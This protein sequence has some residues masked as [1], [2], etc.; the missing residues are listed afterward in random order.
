MLMKGDV[1]LATFILAALLVASIV[2]FA[3]QGAATDEEAGFVQ[4]PKVQ[5][6]LAAYN[7]WQAEYERQGGARNLILP[8]G[9]SK[10]LSCEFTTARGRASFDL[11]DGSLA[12]E[13]RGLPDEHTWEVWLVDNGVGPRNSIAPESGDAMVGIGRLEHAAGLARLQAQLKPG[14]F[15]NFDV[16]LVVVARDGEAPGKGGILFGAPSLFQRFYHSAQGQLPG[17]PSQRDHSSKTAPMTA[18]LAANFFA[19]ALATATTSTAALPATLA[20]LVEDGEVIFFSEKFNGNGRTCGT[21]HRPENNMTID[22][23]F[24]ATLP[25]ED[26]LFVAEFNPA[27]QQ[28]FE[29]PELMRRFGLILENLDGFDDLENKFVMRGVPHVL[30]LQTSVNSSQGP[31]AGWSGDGSANGSL[32]LFA[33]SAVTQH[34]TQT[35]N[36]APGV[37]FR[38]PTEAEMDALEAFLLSLG[39]Q[40]DLTLPLP[41][42]G[43]IPARGQEIFN[44]PDSGKC[45]ACHLNAGANVDPEIFPPDSGNLN[46]DSGVEDFF[47]IRDIFSGESIPPD[48]GSGTPGNGEF[49]TPPLVEAADTGPFFH[50]N[51]ID[52]LEGAVAFYNT[53]AFNDSPAGQ[54]LIEATGSG[55]NLNAIEIV[56][57]G[58]FLRVLNALENI[59]T[60]T[61][62][63]ERATQ[64]D[65]GTSGKFLALGIADIK[66]GSGVLGILHLDAQ[67]RMLIARIYSD[68]AASNLDEQ[69]RNQLINVAIL[70][71]Q[72][73]REQMI[74]GQPASI[75][76]AENDAVKEVLEDAN[77]IS[78]VVAGLLNEVGV[79]FSHADIRDVL[80]VLALEKLMAG[81]DQ[82]VGVKDSSPGSLPEN[83]ALEQNYP[84]PFNP[85]TEIRYQ[86]PVSEHVVIKVFNALGQEILTLV[87]GQYEAGQ[88][89]VRWDGRDKKGV[90]V[91]SGVYIYQIQAGTFSQAKQMSLL[92]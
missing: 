60:A 33:A 75:P 38:L 64:L 58:G 83:Y 36:R 34:F 28:N 49:N 69:Q 87:D 19:A 20:G 65:L 51:L 17:V 1:K 56:Y 50:N 32:R 48:D 46:F 18:G 66:D 15:T 31:H 40:E 29:N 61:A 74:D 55:I 21:C 10:G 42:K 80:T 91:S 16:D 67:I 8:L 81:F 44:D 90:P 9:W 88:H 24:I 70:L 79:T 57:V 53:G 85:E 52:I 2:K 59:R 62:N 39:R 35:L 71:L 86:L 78:Q 73:A 45:F 3:W 25:N 72:G 13:V 82:V 47:D 63:L 22:P 30:A 89:S 77:V 26:P 27:L 5:N 23:D 84:N 54:L 41:L 76:I 12:V 11:V 6:L 14:I 92:K 68:I 4:S 7:N 37:D 43:F